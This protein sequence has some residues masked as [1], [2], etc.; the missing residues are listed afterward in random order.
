MCLCPLPEEVHGTDA[1]IDVRLRRLLDGMVL[2]ESELAE[3]STNELN[4]KV[5]VEP[6]M[7]QCSG[8]PLD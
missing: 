7:S 2:S 4:K 8:T 6:G 1:A 3:F 5:G